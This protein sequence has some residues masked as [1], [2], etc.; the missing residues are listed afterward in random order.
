MATAAASA[1]PTTEPS[2][3]STHTPS[4]TLTPTD[5]LTPTITPS[6]T[7]TA[8]FT[9]S[10]TPEIP[11]IEIGDSANL[12]ASS[13]LTPDQQRVQY[14]FVAQTG[15]LI[16]I[17]MVSRPGTFEPILALEDAAGA[18][19]AQSSGNTPGSITN[20]LI[21]ADGTYRVVAT[22]RDAVAAP[23]DFDFTFQR[24]QGAEFDPASNIVLIPVVLDQIVSGTISSES[25]FASYLLQVN[26]GDTVTI[27]MKNTSGDLDPYLLLVNRATR[28]VVAENDD[29]TSS[30]LDARL[31]RITL[32]EGGTYIILATRYAGQTGT[33]SGTFSLQV[34]RN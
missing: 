10:P 22:A 1:T 26:P 8:T 15:D 3:T 18:L 9:P 34:I 19:L 31:D 11:T 28:Q 25:A 5:T 20:F 30:S 16:N 24:L 33:T 17:S 2:P 13:Q 14:V 27:E 6:A 21:P 32:Q 29:G 7:P 23:A 12:V 4:P